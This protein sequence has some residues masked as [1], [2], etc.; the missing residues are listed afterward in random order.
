MK[1][2]QR[3]VQLCANFILN[4]HSREL[5]ADRKLLLHCWV[6]SLHYQEVVTVKTLFNNRGSVLK[7]YQ[8]EDDICLPVWEG[9]C[10]LGRLCSGFAVLRRV[11]CDS[12]VVRTVDA[13]WGQR[14]LQITWSRLLLPHSGETEE[15]YYQKKK[16]NIGFLPISQVVYPRGL[17][18]LF[19]IKTTHTDKANLQQLF[20]KVRKDSKRADSLKKTY[21][22]AESLLRPVP[23][24][25]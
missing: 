25:F 20:S 23:D 11:W 18:P 5:R 16:W 6:W 21:T 12:L 2:L 14:W 3:S 9:Q 4:Q 7:L 24:I 19:R 17:R 8:S 22:G 10:I 1:L 13:L 15:K